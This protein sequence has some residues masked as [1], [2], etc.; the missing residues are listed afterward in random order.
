MQLVESAGTNTGK[1][2]TAASIDVLTLNLLLGEI[3][4]SLIFPLAS[5]MWSVSL[6]HVF[7]NLTKGSVLIAFLRAKMPS[8]A[9]I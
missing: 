1:L 9:F 2:K 7:G 4:D 8:A 6:F 5:Y 3:Q